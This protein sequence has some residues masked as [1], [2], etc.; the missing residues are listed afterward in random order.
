MDIKMMKEATEYLKQL[1][2][3][4]SVEESILEEQEV[5][6]LPEEVDLVVD[7]KSNVKLFGYEKQ[8]GIKAKD[9]LR[10]IEVKDALNMKYVETNILSPSA[11]VHSLENKPWH[12]TTQG[13][14]ITKIGEKTKKYIKEEILRTQEHYGKHGMDKLWLPCNKELDMVTENDIIC[15]F[16]RRISGWD[17]S[18]DRP[19]IELLGAGGHLQAV[20]DDGTKKFVSLTLED[21]LKKEFSEEIGLS[22]EREDINCIGGFLNYNTQELVIFSCI[23]IEE[24]NIP[25][26]QNYALNNVDEDTDGIY[27]GTF[28][29]AMEYYR[30]EPYFFAGGIEA[31]YTNF[32]N[33]EEI[34]RKICEQYDIKEFFDT[35]SIRGQNYEA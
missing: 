26:I 16:N 22:I 10:I 17:G 7:E 35:K 12:I 18:I 11:F 31:S 4:S 25:N 33:N 29:E 6:Y 2:R 15:I 13:F 21:N 23:Y 24:E 20:W 34:M 3:I 8:K 5:L 27:L 30:K 1:K 19:V 28:R 9:L 32:P 14:L